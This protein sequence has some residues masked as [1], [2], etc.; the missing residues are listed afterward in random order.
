[1]IEPES[2]DSGDFYTV[3]MAQDIQGDLWILK[4]YDVFNDKTTVLGGTD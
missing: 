1:V 4:L 3:W 2:T